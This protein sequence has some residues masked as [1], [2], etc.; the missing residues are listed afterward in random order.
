MTKK[1]LFSLAIV[2]YGFVQAQTYQWAKSIGGASSGNNPQRAYALATDP[3]GNV[4]VTGKFQ[5]TNINFNSGSG[6]VVLSSKSN[7]GV[8]VV[9]FAK[10]GAGGNCIWAK[11]IT[12]PSGS[13]IVPN[14]ASGAGLAI[15]VDTNG[16]VLIAGG[17]GGSKIDFDPGPGTASFTALNSDIFLAKYNRNGNYLWANVIG[18]S[19]NENATGISLDAT[20]NVYMTGRFQ[21]TVD[22]DPGVGVANLNSAG[23]DDIFLAKYSTNGS[24]LWASAVGS[25][26]LDISNAVG[27]DAVGNAYITGYFQGSAIDFDPGPGTA[28]LSSSGSNIYFAKYNKNGNYVWAKVLYGSV[29]FSNSLSADALGNIYIAGAVTSSSLDFDPGIGVVNLNIGSN[30]AGFFAKYDSTG[31]YLLAKSLVGCAGLQS[32]TKNGQGKIFIAGQFSGATDFDT[33]P[34]TVNLRTTTKWGDV[35]FAK[36]DA[37]GNYIWAK[38]IVAPFSDDYCNSVVLDVS[39]NIFIAGAY[40]GPKVDFDLGP[41][42]AI[43]SPVY[44]QDAFVA[45]Y[46][47]CNI[48]TSSQNSICAGGSYAINGHTYAVEGFYTDTLYT[49][50]G[51]DS[52]VNTQLNLY[53]AQSTL[54]V[55]SSSLLCTGSSNTLIASGAQTYTWSNGAQTPVIVV[56]PKDT[57]PYFVIGTDLSGCI[58]SNSVGVYTSPTLSVFGRSFVCRGQQAVLI[59]GGSSTYT[60]NTGAQTASI[61]VAPKGTGIYTVIG[62]GSN[63]ACQSQKSFT[64]KTASC[65]DLKNLGQNVTQLN[66]YPNP[67]TNELFYTLNTNGTHTYKITDLMGGAALEGGQSGNSG[68][69]D[70]STLT[71]GIYYLTITVDKSSKTVRFV[72]E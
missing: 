15:A 57:T 35:F 5:G 66:I 72:K 42:S 44:G 50:F 56:T 69:I 65:I 13:G 51:C 1:F 48:Q 52:I 45:K 47:F 24:Y 59:A 67:A 34:D 18:G 11:T 68:R 55:N 25:K 60:W 23:S 64:V 27:T 63:T 4:Y 40:F 9:F 26:G 38:Q 70:L 39:D 43:F 32:I 61:V 22:F 49:N 3:T 46:R 30:G 36:Y 41:D 17:F 37:K 33:G 16:N 53:T 2:F 62:T 19:G 6:P 71:P 29:G 21:N 8:S 31:A 14:S 12:V 58:L 7:N 28:T 10:Y 20:G 54:A